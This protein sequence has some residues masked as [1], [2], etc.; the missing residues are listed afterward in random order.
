[1]KIK[2]F[3]LQKNKRFNYTPRYYEGKEQGNAFEMGSR[4]RKDREMVTNHFTEEWRAIR[5]ESRNRKNAGVNKT[6]WIIFAIL[7]LIT[8]Y[9]LDFDLS[10]FK[11]N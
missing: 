11:R 6:F 5:S 1:M 9:F 3:Q 2:L 4:I 10:I 7:L 8:L